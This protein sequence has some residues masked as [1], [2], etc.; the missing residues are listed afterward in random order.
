MKNIYPIQV[1]D[2]RLQV[3]HV[4]PKKNQLFDEHRGDPDKAQIDARSITKKIRRRE[5]KIEDGFS[6]NKITENKLLKKS[7]LNLKD[8][9]KKHN[10][11][12]DAMNESELKK[13]CNYSIYSRDSII[14]T[15]K[16]MVSIDNGSIEGTH[17]TCFYMKDNFS[18]ESIAVLPDNFST[19]QIPKPITFY[20]YKT[21]DIDS[22]LCGTYCLYFFYPIES[23][24]Y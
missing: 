13:V 7:R 17:W 12:D 11:K 15:D 22:K 5:L 9:V 18:F 20:I 16:G 21:Q 14:T 24:D 23:M 2:L 8:F 6:R 4:N 10:F 3:D 19:N 1:I